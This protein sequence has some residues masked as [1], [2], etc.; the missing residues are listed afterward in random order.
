MMPL[1]LIEQQSDGTL[2]LT[3]G[4]ASCSGS[5]R[6]PVKKDLISE[7]Q[8][9]TGPKFKERAIGRLSNIQPRLSIRRGVENQS[10]VESRGLESPAAPPSDRPPQRLAHECSGNRIA[11]FRRRAWRSRICSLTVRSGLLAIRVDL[12][13]PP[14]C[15]S[16]IVWDIFF[17]IR[18]ADAARRPFI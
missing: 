4:P 13:P 9:A 17:Q 1:C 11:R 16:F 3:E 18:C 14:R 10:I 8:S 7:T 6:G 5:L 2:S 12:T 15:P